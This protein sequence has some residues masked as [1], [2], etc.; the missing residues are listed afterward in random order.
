MEET[1]RRFAAYILLGGLLLTAS[2]GRA[3][4]VA[5][6]LTEIVVTSDTLSIPLDVTGSNAMPVGLQSPPEARTLLDSLACSLY[7]AENKH[8]VA[9]NWMKTTGVDLTR[10]GDGVTATADC[11]NFGGFHL[12]KAITV[13]DGSPVVQVC[14]QLQARDELRPQVLVPAS[15]VCAPALNH[16]VTPAGEVAAAD[17]A[18]EGLGMEL[19]AE[20]YGFRPS[21][22][23]AGIALVPI[24]WP[25]MHR[26]EYVRRGQDGALSLAMRLHPMRTFK[27][28]DDVRFAYNLIV[29][30]GDAAEA[31]AT[32]KQA[33][34]G[35]LPQLPAVARTLGESPAA[36]GDG[37]RVTRCP[38]ATTV[39]V[40]DGRLDDGCWE[41]GGVMDRFVSIDG[42][43]FAEGATVARLLH[44]GAMTASS[45]SSTP[46]GMAVAMLT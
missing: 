33:G 18:S 9:E 28:G 3:V 2:A 36:L 37:L 40:L 39:P 14:Y 42:R 10:T 13:R 44:G 12:R 35:P 38:S 16:L 5:Q 43:Q 11:G 22:G 7:Y 46:A 41:Q 21:T 26:V 31:V 45:C 23:D 25:E 6:S 29:F 17:V 24:E 4:E 19:A 8:W 1:R 15:L 27:P 30:T 20:W 32:A 34:V